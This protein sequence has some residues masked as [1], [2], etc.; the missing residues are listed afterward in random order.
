LGNE[1]HCTA[2]GVAEL[3]GE[4]GDAGDFIEWSMRKELEEEVGLVGDDLDTLAPIAFCRELLRAGKPQFFFLGVTSL[5]LP[6]I[7]KK[8]KGARRRAKRVGDI[9]E[10]MALPLLRNPTSLTG[11]DAVALQ[12]RTI[13]AEAAACLHYFFRCSKD[14]NQR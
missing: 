5:P 9:I 14:G 1:W 6:E 10:N 3:R 11:P 2:S 13:S 4:D 7:T 12:G 8:L